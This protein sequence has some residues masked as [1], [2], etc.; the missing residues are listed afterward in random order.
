VLAWLSVYSEVQM[1]CIWSCWC[2]WNPIISCF[3]KIENAFLP[4]GLLRLSWKRG[5]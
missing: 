2:C 1:I 3:I 5:H 4:T